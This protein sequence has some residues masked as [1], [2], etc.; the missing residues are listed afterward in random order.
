[1]IRLVL[2]CVGV[3]GMVAL[4][5]AAQ[6]QEAYCRE[7][8]RSATIGGTL[9]QMYGTACLQPDGSWR[10]AN[11]ETDYPEP[12]V[13]Y[14]VAQITPQPVVYDAYPTRYEDVY[15]PVY[16]P[17]VTDYRY[18][19]GPSFGVTWSSRDHDRRGWRDGHGHGGQGWR[20]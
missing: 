5:G 1:M 4:T 19:P 15:E 11:G 3:A 12:G 7:Y 14:R 20:H 8:Q 6:A 16:E 13:D 18:Y 17:V 9:Q 10:I 2:G